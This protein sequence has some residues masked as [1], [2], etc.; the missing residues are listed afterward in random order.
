MNMSNGRGVNSA[1][2]L[3]SNRSHLQKQVPTGG[4]AETRM[5]CIAALCVDSAY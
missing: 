4:A 1:T 3:Q 5:S 2:K